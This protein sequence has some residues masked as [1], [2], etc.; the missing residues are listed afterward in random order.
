[1]QRIVIA[2]ILKSLEASISP[3]YLHVI[4]ASDLWKQL[5]TNHAIDNGLAKFRAFRALTTCTQGNETVI[6]YY[7][8]LNTIW[9]KIKNNTAGLPCVCCN[10]TKNNNDEKVMFFLGGLHDSYTN[11]RGNI[12]MMSSVPEID[13][14]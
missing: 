6:S 8:R 9:V 13:K 2:W 11:V 4:K 12:L 5:Q 3:N 1:M 7:T 10:C 14:V